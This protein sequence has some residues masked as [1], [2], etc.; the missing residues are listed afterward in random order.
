MPA[1]GQRLQ[2]IEVYHEAFIVEAAGTKQESTVWLNVHV[3]KSCGE[4][5][6]T[7][8]YMKRILQKVSTS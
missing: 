3:S 1:D 7:F 2:L 6:L 4:F 8:A 5:L